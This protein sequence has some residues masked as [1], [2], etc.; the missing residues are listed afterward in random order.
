MRAPTAPAAEAT[1]PAPSP[2]TANAV[3]GSDSA[4]STSVHAAQF[5]IRSGASSLTNDFTELRSLRSKSSM[6][7]PVTSKLSESAA[8]TSVPSMPAAPVTNA[9]FTCSPFVPAVPYGTSIL[10][11]S[12]TMNL[13]ALGMDPHFLISTS[14]PIRLLSMR[15]PRLHMLEFSSTMLC[16]I[17]EFWT[18]TS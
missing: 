18:V 7:A 14:F 10:L 11:A 6:S 17:S 1:L 5:T 9:L 3:A 2:L 4:P 13:K 12:P 8:A 15:L 16:S